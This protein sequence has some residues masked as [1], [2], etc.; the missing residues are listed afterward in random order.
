MMR[1]G[2]SSMMIDKLISEKIK[3]AL[4]IEENKINKRIAA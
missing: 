3:E 2:M 1:K 4:D